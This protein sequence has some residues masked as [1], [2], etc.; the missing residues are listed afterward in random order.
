MISL[1]KRQREL[2]LFIDQFIAKN[3][4]G[5]SFQEMA[6]GTGMKSRSSVH[7]QLVAIENKGWIRR[8]KNC[9]RAIEIL[10]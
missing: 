5:P 3:G 1:T 10:G 6:N 8:L 4:Y 7:R 2:Y 9:A